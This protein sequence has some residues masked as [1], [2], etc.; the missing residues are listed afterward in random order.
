M[1]DFHG[2]YKRYAPHVHRFALF[3]C[4]DP[5]LADDI[6]SETFVRAWTSPGPI[7]EGTVKAYLFTI[8]RNLY[9]DF[10][11]RARRRAVLHEN[12]ADTRA[13]AA[14]QAHVRSEL[15]FVL[16]AMQELPEIDR[17]ALLMRAREE[18][19]Y[20]EIAQAL[21][22]SVGAVK[23]KIHRARAK[24]LQ[25]ISARNERVLGSEKNV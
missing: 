8:A 20:E 11:R 9:H 15:S 12:I 23:V 10:L 17:A 1:T 2:L 7:R 21:D 14:E 4:G 16:A 19:S 25:R 22:L 5:A 18:M 13:D 3:L 24:L 6:T